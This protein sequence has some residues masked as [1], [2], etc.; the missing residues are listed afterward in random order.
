MVYEA[1]TMS[2]LHVRWLHEKTEREFR[3]LVCDE[4]RKVT[5]VGV[6]IFYSGCF[7]VDVEGVP[8][9]MHIP[10]NAVLSVGR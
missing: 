2:A 8:F 10:T 9:G 6:P 3:L 5:D 4:F 1:M 7:V